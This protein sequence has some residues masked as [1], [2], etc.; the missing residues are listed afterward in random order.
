MAVPT[1]GVVAGIACRHGA[2]DREGLR[3]ASGLGCEVLAPLLRQW[4]VT[5]IELAARSSSA[6]SGG[7][8]AFREATVHYRH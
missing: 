8:P 5:A 7:E 3:P 4:G 2:G 1:V 6:L